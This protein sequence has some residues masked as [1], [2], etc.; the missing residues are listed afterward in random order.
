MA[1]Q[2]PEDDGLSREE[3]IAL[4]RHLREE[5]ERLKRSQHRQAAPGRFVALTV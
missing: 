3:L 5:I 4:V 1:D 2:H